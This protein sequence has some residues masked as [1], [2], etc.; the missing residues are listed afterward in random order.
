MPATSST[1]SGSAASVAAQPFDARGV[2]VAVMA[3]RHGG[4]ERNAPHRVRVDAEMQRSVRGQVRLRGEHGADVVAVVV[5]AGHEAPRQSQRTE[6][7]DGR[8][9][10]PGPPLVDEVAGDQHELGPAIETMEVSDRG[11]E[12]P[13]RI[14]DVL[15]EESARTD[16]HVGALRNQHGGRVAL[17]VGAYASRWHA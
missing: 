2:D 4:V 12:Q 17:A 3:A 13:V 5:I 1:G 10:L 14:D 6:Y 7:R 11:G 16:V 15:V 9:I 8:L